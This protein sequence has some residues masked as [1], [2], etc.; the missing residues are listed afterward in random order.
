MSSVHFIASGMAVHSD[1]LDAAHTNQLD[2]NIVAAITL[3]G[4]SH[5][6]TGASHSD[7]AR[8]EKQMARFVIFAVQI[9]YRHTLADLQLL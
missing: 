6:V 3:V 5:E 9:Q 7:A 1:A 8:L 4:K 2:A